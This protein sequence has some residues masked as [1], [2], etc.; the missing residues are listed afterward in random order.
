[1]K[2]AIVILHYANKDLTIQCLSSIRELSQNDFNLQVIVVNNNHKENLDDLEKSFGDFV[3]LKTKKNLGFTG[4]NN[5]GIKRALRDGADF[6][7]L[8][9]NDTILDKDCLVYLVKQACL[10]KESAILGPKIY[11]AP[12]HEYHQGKYKPSD[13]GKA[14]WYAGGIVDWKN[15][16][17]SHRGVDEIDK[18]QYDQTE[19]TDFVSGCAMLVKKEVFQKIGLLDDKYFLYLEDNDFCQRAKKAGFKVI[20]APKAKVWHI[21]AGSSEVGGSLH[22]YYLTR[23]RL[24]FGIKYANRQTKIAL[25]RESLKL[26]VSGRSW[27]KKGVR[28]FYLRKFGKGSYST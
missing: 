22:D 17:A 6:V 4:G 12:G 3:F 1:M 27:Q 14:I 19:Q 8:L 11:F 5:L 7:F 28:D 21:N 15:V 25:L 16:L 26:L 9:N 23:N 2:I 24:I 18:G 13:Q 20:Y 10:T